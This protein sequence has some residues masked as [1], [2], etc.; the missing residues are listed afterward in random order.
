MGMIFREDILTN[1][2][3]AMVEWRRYLHMNPELSYQES[4]TSEFIA[5][6]LKDWGI[7]VQ[8]CVGGY[9]VVGNLRGRSAGPT[10]ALRADMD[11]L[12]IQDEKTSTYA[13]QVPGVMHAC[14]H[15]GHTSTLLG[16]AYY[17][18]QQRDML[19]GNVRFIFQ[20]AEETCPGGAIQMIEDGVLEGV[21]AIYGVHLW[22][23]IP[24]GTT[25]SVEGPMW[26]AADEFF[27][28]IEGKGGHGGVPQETVDSV[29][30]GAAM[31]MNIQTIVSR[32]VDPMEP[33]VVTVGSMQAG[34]VQNII[35]ERCHISGTVRTFQ[36]DVRK[37][38]RDRL[39][40]IV[41]QTCRMYGAQVK[42]DYRVG[43]P[44]VVND[45]VETAR[46]RRVAISLFG[47][48]RTQIAQK[49]MPG[50][51]FAYY[52]QRVP[53]C[54]I[55]VGAGN[56]EQGIVHPHHHPRFDIDEEAMY[57]AAKLLIHLAV[58]YLSMAECDSDVE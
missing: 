27:I 43:Y 48:E 45:K 44:P 1:M 39:E 57:Q 51:D 15:D 4:K 26:A 29:L 46:Y 5:A 25:A 12:P 55:L 49:M 20:P 13:S 40:N 58:D 17:F 41:E 6:K 38:V 53:G 10:V 9:G 23:P 24:V 47:E 50:E 31:I 42:L 37:R 21:D 18:S 11:A 52:L 8:T 28:D 56:A 34:T 7:E 14:G 3:N 54:F 32:S 30:V 16:I 19:H 36:D 22:T 35:A 2:Y 33:A